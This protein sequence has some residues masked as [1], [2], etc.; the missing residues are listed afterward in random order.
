MSQASVTIE[1]ELPR[2]RVGDADV[3]E[4]SAELRVLWAIEQVRKR[5]CG[6]GKGAELAGLPRAAFMRL[7][8]EY[9][10]PVIDYPEA[11]LMEELKA[12]GGR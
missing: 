9:G 7:L 8:G 2:D 12:V 4:L 1:V 11:D 5:R 10:I 6:V 3:A